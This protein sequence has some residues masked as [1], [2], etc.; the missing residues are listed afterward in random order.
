VA[1]INVAGRFGSIT[2]LGPVAVSLFIVMAAPTAYAQGTEDSSTR[3]IAEFETATQDYALMHRG[4]EEKIG[5][6]ELGKLAAEI[7][8]IINELATAIRRERVAAKQGDL[9]APTL[10]QVLRA[11]ISDALLEHE[12]TAADARTRVAGV[13]YDRL[14]LRVNDTFPLVLGVPMLSCVRNA[15]PSLPP[16]LQYRMV[17]DDLVLLDVHAL[18]IIDILPHVLTDVTAPHP[19]PRGGLR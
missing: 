8:R 10:G 4:L 5:P 17:G 6:I 9:F 11:R 13:D 7:N 12:F 15:L 16:E 2:W 1:N 19:G 14:E 3:A 18:L